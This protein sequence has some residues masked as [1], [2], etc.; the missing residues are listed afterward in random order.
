VNL[1]PIC[2]ALID[3]NFDPETVNTEMCVH[4]IGKIAQKIRQ[5]NEASAMNCQERIQ[6]L[7]ALY[8]AFD[9][10][11][12]KL[13]EKLEQDERD[14]VDPSY[15]QLLRCKAFDQFDVGMLPGKRIL[16]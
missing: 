6:T 2:F 5:V 15:I 13:I 7:K 8:V 11:G 4:Y 12:E 14:G 16:A 10:V 3:E 9:T 1:K